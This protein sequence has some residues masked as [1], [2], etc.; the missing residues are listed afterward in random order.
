[1]GTLFNTICNGGTLILATRLNFQERSRHCTV[2]VVTPSILDVLNAPKSPTDYPHLDRIFLG[3]ETP[4]QQLLETW[5]AFN[6]IAL[7][8]AY[9][10]TE[11]T[12][13]VLSHQLRPSHKTGQF[14]PTQLGDCIPG[15]NLVLLDEE[16]GIIQGHDNEGEICIEGPCLTDGYWQDEERSR[17]RFIDYHGRR[18]YR[19]GD[20]GRFVVTD[21]GKTTI[22]FCGRRDR[23]TKIRGFLVNLELDVD[24]G[25]R[26]LD[27]NITTVFSVVLEKKLCTAV[28][29]S[30]I[31]CRKLLASWRQVV[32]PYLVPDRVVSLNDLPLTANGK[33]DPRR[34][35]HVLRDATGKDNDIQNGKLEQAQPNETVNHP[36]S[37]TVGHIIIEGIQQILEISQ[38][39]IDLSQSAVFQGIHS[40]AAARLST[41]CR[42]H[43]Y[44][45]SVEA[46]LTEPS[47]QSL[48]SISQYKEENNTKDAAFIP[49]MPADTLAST[50]G[51]VTPLQQRMVLDSLV[52]DLRANCLQHISWYKTD[53]IGSLRTAWKTVVS[54]EP[55]FRTSLEQDDKHPDDVFQ[56][57]IGASHFAWEEYTATRYE[58]IEKSLRSLPTVTGLGSRFRVLHCVGPELPLHESVFVWAVHHALIDG[59]SASLIFG[60][61]DKALKNQP[62]ECSLPFT[63]AARDIAQM[64]EAMASEAEVFWQDQEKK[65]PEAVGEPLIPETFSDQNSYEF[66]EHVAFI[67][68]D[69]E[70]LRHTSQQAQ[71]TPAAIFYAAWAMLLASYTNSDTVAFGAVFSGRNLPFAWAPS[72]IGPLLN[73]LPLRCRIDRQTESASFVR[74]IHQAIQQLSRFQFEDRRS[75]TPLFATTLTVQDVGLRTRTTAIDS[76]RMPHVRQSTLLPLTVLVETD[77]QI[78]FLYRTDRFSSEHVKDMAAIYISL[79]NALLE[80]D[81]NLQYCID[82]RFPHDMRQAI[83]RSGNIDSEIARV[84]IFNRGNTLSGLLGK[85]AAL[86]PGHIAVEKGPSSIT[87]AALL[88]SA[89][90]VAKV[91]QQKTQPGDVVAIHADR[92][93]NWIIGIFGAMIANTVYCPLDASYAAQYREELL[94][95]SDAGVFL[96]STRAQIPKTDDGATIVAIDDILSSGVEP[97]YPWRKQ[98]PGDAAYLCFTSGS[99]GV[100]KGNLDMGHDVLGTI[101]EHIC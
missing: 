32:P 86:F 36:K 39:E 56:R 50:R 84:P 76:L 41:F 25:L 88:H 18:L 55:I 53:D 33:I 14:H 34:V 19:T 7:W 78:E 100:P 44:A 4:S 23:V 101:L 72:M 43:G 31:D 1:M 74:E 70:R 97:L 40:L 13:A 42:Q 49:S 20:L 27:P 9:G 46:I 51:P 38:N 85:T 57:L 8:I 69:Q 94:R 63:L 48:I 10:P 93:I 26:L 60:N 59:Y 24:A 15:S 90:Q 22:E 12:C 80:P 66:A 29:P 98:A 82:R 54:H 73:I 5:S 87:Y 61:V 91:I 62:F 89:A 37:L 30:S 67:N 81:Q 83:L 92:S 64:R 65:F 3:G 47:I 71:G 99:T 16:N 58:D 75:N 21:D 45:I 96:V 79:I 28:A 77:G 68:V 17:D 95:R 6:N 52:G 35:A 11:A 2:L